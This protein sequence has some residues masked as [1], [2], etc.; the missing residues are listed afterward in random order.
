MVSEILKLFP[1]PKRGYQESIQILMLASVFEMNRLDLRLPSFLANRPQHYGNTAKRASLFVTLKSP[2]LW[3]TNL[4]QS[5]NEGTH[6]G[7]GK[8]H[9]EVL[10]NLLL[11]CAL[12]MD[13]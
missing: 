8:K 13:K 6:N 12:S 1:V 4:V 11:V 5:N 10:Q 7:K 2:A 9:R 3:M